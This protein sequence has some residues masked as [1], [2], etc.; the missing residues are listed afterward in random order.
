MCSERLG[1][2][3][4]ALLCP[5]GRP[6]GALLSFKCV[7]DWHPL[8]TSDMVVRSVEREGSR[9]LQRPEPLRI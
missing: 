2:R 4:R 8:T 7:S 6:Y 1:S 9:R 5:H 3:M